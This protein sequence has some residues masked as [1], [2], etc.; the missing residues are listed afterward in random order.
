MYAAHAPRPKER[1][2]FQTSP[3]PRSGSADN[4]RTARG[5]VCRA[6]CAIHLAEQG[7]THPAIIARWRAP[8]SLAALILA[9]N[10]GDAM[11]G[12]DWWGENG[13]S[14]VFYGAETL[15]VYRNGNGDIA[16][17]Q[18]DSYDTDDVLIYLPIDS[19]ERVANRIL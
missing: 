13:D 3:P 14:I 5:R 2:R 10:G 7:A 18:Q 9:R 15:A 17:R 6:S 1:L 11:S 4:H 16:L 19:A 12:A 8:T